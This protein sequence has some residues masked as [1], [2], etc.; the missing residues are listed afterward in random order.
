MITPHP[1]AVSAAKELH[2][3][4]SEE[5]FLDYTDHSD[6][7]RELFEKAEKERSRLSVIIMRRYAPVLEEKDRC[8]AEL[9]A[10]TTPICVGRQ[11]IG[12]LARDG[13]WLSESGAGVI[14]ADELYR[15]DPYERIA[16]LE[17]QCAAKGDALREWNEW[18]ELETVGHGSTGSIYLKSVAALSPTAGQNYLAP[19]EAEKLRR[20]VATTEEFAAK[21]VAN[22]DARERQAQIRALRAAKDASSTVNGINNLIERL[23]SGFYSI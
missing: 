2:S 1:A 5:W 15:K 14:A 4:Y 9:E 21:L 19:E 23:E 11:I 7:W 8:I 6:K 22:F 10:R 18:W 12:H 20:T 16:E 17:A 3:E 13:Q